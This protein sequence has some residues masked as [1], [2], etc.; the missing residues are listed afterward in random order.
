MKTDERVGDVVTM[1]QVENEPS[2]FGNRKL[3]CLGYRVV[4]FVWSY[5]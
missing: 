2:V 1:S 4:L 3:E 5:V